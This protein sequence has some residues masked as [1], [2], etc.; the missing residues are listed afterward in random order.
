M[1]RMSTSAEL[2]AAGQDRT[3][4]SGT[5][6]V[7]AWLGTR[8]LVALNLAVAADRQ[9]GEHSQDGD[10]PNDGPDEV[11]RDGTALGE[12]PHGVG[13]PGDGRDVGHGLH[14]P[15]PVLAPD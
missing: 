13:G 4:D 9:G 5:A 14:P 7:S 3:R 11:G 10:A 8:R 15:A 6:Q 1:R 2:R 12:G